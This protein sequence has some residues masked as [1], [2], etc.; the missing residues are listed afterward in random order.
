MVGH[1]GCCLALHRLAVDAEYGVALLQSCLGGWHSGVRLIDYHPLACETVADDG[2]NAGILARHH[3]FILAC[4]IL[5][6]IL[7]VGVERVQ[8]G[9]YG[10]AHRLVGIERV[11]IHEV[12]V[13]VYGVEHFEILCHLEIVVARVL[14]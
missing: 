6:K 9:A 12:E 5:G 1:I 2:A 7:G 13:A 14:G 10:C 8:H 3:L 11:D 4:L